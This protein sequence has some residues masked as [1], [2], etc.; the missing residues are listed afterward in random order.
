MWPRAFLFLFLAVGWGVSARAQ[1]G[2][3]IPVPGSESPTQT[4]FETVQGQVRFP[5]GKPAVNVAVSLENG[6]G[7]VL[8]RAATDPT[9]Y[10][11]FLDLPDGD[12]IYQIEVN[13]PGYARYVDSVVSCD[14][15]PRTLFITLTPAA[16]AD[17][18]KDPA[19]P[20]N[21]VTQYTKGVSEMQAGRMAMASTYFQ[22]AVGI[23]PFYMDSFLKLSA[24]EADQHHFHQAQK[25]IDRAMHLGKNDSR[26][27]AY[28]GYLRM[29]EGKPDEAKKQFRH[30]IRLRFSDWLAQL[31]MGRV[32]LNE[33]NAK[34]A[35]PYLSAARKLRPNLPSAH[36]LYYD[37]M[38]MLGRNKD[39]L[40]EL[41]EFL[42][43]FPKSPEAPQLRKV[44]TAL[45]A[46][47]RPQH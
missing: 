39:A 3:T 31:E 37:D 44:R 34:G 23:C 27:Y 10:F 24:T 4:G 35:Y 30:A 41:N 26:V 12:N 25:M 19:I 43:Q 6:Y 38:I 32:L 15:A 7:A 17:S 8:K 13:L 40:K 11:Y 14:M 47:L 16:L 42:T 9:G 5:N 2:M 33:K 29:Q 21:A 45:Q 20:K 22:K 46:S 36:L 28:L 18:K 1:A